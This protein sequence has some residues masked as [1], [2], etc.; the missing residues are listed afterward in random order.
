MSY[1]CSW[2]CQRG[3]SNHLILLAPILEDQTPRILSDADC[4]CSRDNPG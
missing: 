1:T 2:I 4:L 3:T